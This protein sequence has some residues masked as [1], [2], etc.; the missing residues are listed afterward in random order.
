MCIIL[1]VSTLTARMTS[2]VSIL[3][4]LKNGVMH[5][6]SRLILRR[7][8]LIDSILSSVGRVIR[9]I[10]LDGVRIA[11]FAIFAPVDKI[12][13]IDIENQGVDIRYRQNYSTYKII[14]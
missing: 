1:Y 3:K 8:Q 10:G 6:F 2:F 5:N 7:F 4:I 14:S 9:N 12:A 11:R 13:R